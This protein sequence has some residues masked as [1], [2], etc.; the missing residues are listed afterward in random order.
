MCASVQV[1]IYLMHK[2]AAAAAAAAADNTI[3]TSRLTVVSLAYLYIYFILHN[4]LT[5]SAE[6]T[7]LV[8]GFS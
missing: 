7:L 4:N 8:G 1:V 6:Q 2:A 5:A 3:H